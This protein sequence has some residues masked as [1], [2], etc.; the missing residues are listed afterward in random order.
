MSL[1]DVNGLARVPID[2]QH[3]AREIAM[4]LHVDGVSSSADIASLT[5]NVLEL[6]G[7]A[8]AGCQVAERKDVVAFRNLLARGSNQDSSWT[9]RHS[10]AVALRTS[11]VLSSTS[12]AETD[13]L[14]FFLIAVRLSQDSDADVRRASSSALID[15][16]E[17][18][19]PKRRNQATLVLPSVPDYLLQNLDSTLYSDTALKIASEY[20]QRIEE[21]LRVAVSEIRWL[22]AALRVDDDSL[23]S[24]EL[25]NTNSNRK[26]FEDESVETY[27]EPQL[28][29]QTSL[30]GLLLVSLQSRTLTQS[31]RALANRI[32]RQCRSVLSHL[33]DLYGPSSS[34]LIHDVTG[35]ANIFP[36]L[37]NLLLATA[38]VTLIGLPVQE[39]IVE[40]CQLASGL[41]TMSQS[42]PLY[43]LIRQ[44]LEVVAHPEVERFSRACYLLSSSSRF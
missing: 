33:C 2:L 26:I 38:V 40:T 17:L 28:L 39:D 10:A 44:A 15:A 7:L 19:G 5:G 8:L 9:L 23:R 35:E 18:V 25:V 37:H 11:G 4:D 31:D 24:S 14:D 21:S 29:V 1:V 16:S 30:R 43:P 22:S 12:L 36:L 42:R 13:R 32:V 6:L 27:C 41:L 3:R 20:T 34:H